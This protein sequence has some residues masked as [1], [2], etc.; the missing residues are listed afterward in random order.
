[1][2]CLVQP[3]DGI[4][5]LIRA[6]KGARKSIEILVFRFNNNQLERALTD[7]VRR[8]VQVHAL[9]AHTNRGGEQELRELEQRFLANGITVSRTPN[10]LARYHGKLMVVDRRLLM[11]LAFN[12][13]VLD[14]ERSRSFGII[15]TNRRHVVEAM[16]LLDADTNRT[17]YK[18]STRTF[19]VSPVNARQL[20]TAYIKAARKELLIYDPEVS[21]PAMLAL[22]KQRAEAGVTVKII[23]RVCAPSDLLT[24]RELS[25]LRLHT[26][27]IIRD[28]R[29]VFVGSQSLR[30]SE[31]EKRRE[32]GIIVADRPVVARL[33]ATFQTDWESAEISQAGVAAKRAGGQEKAVPVEKIAK[34][35]AKAVVREMGEVVPAVE[36]AVNEIAPDA[37]TVTLN[38]T[39]VRT[40][41]SEAVKDAVEGVVR[42]L[43]E[44]A[45]ESTAVSEK[46]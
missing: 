27:A 29:H 11:L 1:M 41:V 43:V 39:D 42:E 18:P 10:K 38:H 15:T 23:G 20:L 14:I 17:S 21:D 19:L 3:D 4:E 2:V 31:L 37:I 35:V 7:A 9:V 40:N 45:A 16:K 8:G 36:K 24:V 34:K 30:K 22:L 25:Q 33:T 28:G 6:L 46:P 12:F 44:Q 26:R 13:T 32:V 5:P